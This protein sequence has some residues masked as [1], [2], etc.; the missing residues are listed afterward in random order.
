MLPAKSPQ[1]QAGVRETST[2]FCY[3]NAQ[4]VANGKW[5]SRW[6]WSITA[7]V[8]NTLLVGE[9]SLDG[10]VK[11]VTGS[12]PM[13]IQA[14]AGAYAGM[15]PAL[16]QRSRCG[17]DGRPPGASG[18]APFPGGE[19]SKRYRRHRP[20]TSRSRRHLEL[21]GPRGTRFRGHKRPGTR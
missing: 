9:P 6:G 20:G 2:E 12:L 16:G 18:N 14:R 17:C 11:P 1:G 13:A 4:I 7:K 15:P 8:V 5:G 21:P 19:L 3:R 10:R